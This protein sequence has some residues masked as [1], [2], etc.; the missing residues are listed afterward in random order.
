MGALL[1][2]LFGVGSVSGATSANE[3]LRSGDTVGMPFWIATAM[4]FAATIF[5]ILER[6][7]TNKRIQAKASS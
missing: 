3:L 1:A 5:F 7:F 4:M 6:Q 2:V